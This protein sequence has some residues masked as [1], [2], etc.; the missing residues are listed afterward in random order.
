MIHGADPWWDIAIR[1]LIKY[2][3]LRLMTSAWSPK[4][5]PGEPAALHADA[6]T[7]QGDLRVGLAGAA[8]APRRA[9]GRGAG[10]AGRRAGELSVQQRTDEFFFRRP[11]GTDDGP[12]RTA[13]A[14]LQPLE[15]HQATCRRRTGSS[16]RRTVRSTRCAPPRQSGFD[17]SLWERLCAMGATTMALPESSGGRRGDAGRPHA[18][19]R[20]D[21]P[22]AGAGAVD[23][24]RLC[25]EAARAGWARW[26]PR[27]RQRQ[28][29]R[30]ARSAARTA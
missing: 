21:R 28:A 10:P 17:K 13:Q 23:R 2:Q 3:N 16:S 14:R 15:D 5:L 4:R 18:G 20:G 11:E 22:L 27:R 12:V 25:R 29:D 19:G 9:G 26:T 1:L 7:G 8:H 24:P 30:R 6:R